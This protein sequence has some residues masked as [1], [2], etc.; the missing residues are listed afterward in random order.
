MSDSLAFADSEV[1]AVSSSGEGV[2][3]RLSAA[4]VL[5]SDAAAPSRPT[6]GFA[7]AVELFLPGARLHQEPGHCLG[8]IAHGRVRLG[9][10]WSAT[11]ALP[12]AAEQATTLELVFANQSSL[13]L[14][15]HGITC[16]YEGEANFSE[17]L[18][19]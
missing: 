3:I 16:R 9:H 2:R 5:R 19:C 7:R 17:S 8:R 6:A 15:A 18:F 14:S 1:A 13:S 12:F 10:R 4:H 11:L